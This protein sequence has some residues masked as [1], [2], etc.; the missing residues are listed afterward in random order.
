MYQHRTTGRT[1]CKTNS[2]RISVDS[3][4]QPC[5]VEVIV[6]DGGRSYWV[7]CEPLALSTGCLSAYDD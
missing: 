2:V 4:S 3:V 5:T 6:R 1:F 7:L